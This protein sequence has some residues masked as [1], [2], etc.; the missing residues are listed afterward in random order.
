MRALVYGEGLKL[1][2]RGEPIIY[3][4]WV[5]GSA[6]IG[7]LV[8]L[9]DG[10]EDLACGLVDKIGVRIL[11]FEPCPKRPEEL[12][13]EILQLAQDAKSLLKYEAYRLIN[14]DGD[15]FPGL[16]VDVYKDIAVLQSSSLAIDK[17]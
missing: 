16:I 17:H 10:D 1:L 3:R 9:S 4:R 2:L 8:T 5:K 7:S 13:A 11:S 15:S 12:F 14:G 6:P